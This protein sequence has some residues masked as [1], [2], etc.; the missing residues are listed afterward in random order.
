M[1]N[2]LWIMLLFLCLQVLAVSQNGYNNW[3]FGNNAGLDFSKG[4]PVALLNGSLVTADNSVTVSDPQTGELLFYSNG[5]KVWDRNHNVM[6]NGNDL[7]GHWSGG[8]SAIA[9]KLPG[10]NQ[11]YYLFT[12]DAF[13]WPNGLRYSVIDLDMNDGLG[14]VTNQKN[15]VLIER[16]TEKIAITKHLNEKDYWIVTHPWNSDEYHV[17]LL[18]EQGLDPIPTISKIGIFHGGD[19]YNAM[20]QIAFSEDGSRIASAV[21]HT[22]YE[23]FNFDRSNGRLSDQIILNGHSN[24]W[25][26]QFSK[27]NKFLYSTRWMSDEIIQFDLS[28]GLQDT[29]NQFY[30]IIGNATS[31]NSLYK[32]GY[33]QT[34]PDNR[35][36]V[37]KFDSQYLGAIEMNEDN[38]LEVRYI[39]EAVFLGGRTSQAGL[40]NPVLAF[41]P[42]ETLS[43]Y[44]DY[45]FE[46]DSIVHFTGI[47][48]NP[49]S[50]LWSHNGNE[51]S[52]QQNPVFTFPISGDYLICVTVTKGSLYAEFCD[53]VNICI[54][55]KADFEY[56]F[57]YNNYSFLNKSIHAID[58]IWDFGDGYFSYNEHTYHQ[59]NQEGDYLVVLIAKNL[60]S[61][62]TCSILLNVLN[63]NS[64]VNGIVPDFVVYPNPNSGNFSIKVFESNEVIVELFSK[65]GKLV[66]HDKRPFI[67][68]EEHHYI[69]DLMSGSYTIRVIINNRMFE[70]KLIILNE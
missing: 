65:E 64:S 9:V 52:S 21:Y 37:A 8:T 55:P 1:F 67:A 31:P 19:S 23:I 60:C 18:T 62:D 57:N 42:A 17:Y 46:N 33:L 66:Y 39:D 38:E 15:I 13:A 45:T 24:A 3:Y 26:V 70:K 54:H 22:H 41:P 44:F 7:L 43:V 10:N 27:D 20:G 53:T 58:Y 29:I 14:D 50:W 5:V 6:P 56:N 59:Y 4:Y 68:F 63:D 12:T 30:K 51:L 36:Y 2:S 40:P 61:S 25:G 47:S 16:S 28:I 48:N 32:A 49:E 35:I 69:M 34:G 11:K